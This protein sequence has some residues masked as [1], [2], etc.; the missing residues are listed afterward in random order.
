[1]SFINSILKAFVGDK[2]E[3]DVKAIQPLL[4]K[5]KTF[6]SYLI[7]LSHD[8]LRAKTAFFKQTI[9]D[10]RAEKDAK[11]AALKEEVE[12]ISDIDQR[13]DLYVFIDTLEKEAYE[14]SE[15]VLLEILPEAF[16]VVKETARRF[17]E[18]TQIK[19]TASTKDIELSATKSYVTLE[20][21]HAVWANSWNAA[22]KEI[23][24]DMIHYDVQLIGG[25]VL[26]QGK[27]AEMQT[28]EGKTLVA[29]LPLYLNAL[30]GNGVHLVTV[31]D[32]LAKRDSTWK[33]P[34]FEFHGLTVD[35][36]DN[37]QPNTESRRKAYEADITYGTN[38]EFGFDYLRDNM[39]HS[40][41][42]LV[43]RKHN[44]AIVDEVDSVLIDDA[45]T[46]LIIS[47]PVPQGDRHE[48]NEL[49]P[50]VDNLVTLQR[51]LATQFLTEAK[52][53]IKEG[54]TKD[55][56]F[57]LLR[58]YRSLP[59][60]KALIKFLSEEGIKQ[61]LQKTENHYMQD[62]NREMPKVDEALYFVIEEKNNQVELTDNGIKFLSKDT[63]ES[64]FVLP[65][66]GSEIARIEKMR[67]EKDAEAEEK[68]KLFQ[69]FSIKSE[70]IHTLTQL[71]KAYTLFEKD[72]EYVIM[73]DK[74][75]IVDEQTGRI[76]EGRRYSDGLHQAIEAKENVKI[77]AA[78][79]TFA[80]VTLQNYFRMYSKLAG[81]T[82][83]AVT[84][85][86]ELWQI[87][88]LDVVE[89]PTNRPM[90]RKDQEDLIYKTT[91]EKFNAVIEDVTKLSQ[92]GRPV[93]IG[94][95]SV[96]ISELLS[97]MLKMRN[98][99]HNVLN[100]KMH[101]KEAD[102]VAEA[103]KPG[104]VTIATNMAGRGTDIKLTPEVKAAG[105]LAIIGTERH[106][107]RR[108]DRQL[109]GRAG[110]QGDPGSSQFYVSLEDN[111]MRLFGSERV[112]KVMDRMGLKEGEVIQHSM[113]TKSIER[114]QKKVEENNF[115]VRKRLL[116]YDDVMNSQREVVYKRRRHALHGERLKVDIANMIY[117]T[118]ENIVNDNKAVS[119][120]KN[121]EFDLIRY[122]SISSPVSEGE[123]SKLTEVELSGKVYKVALAYYEEK[124]ARDARESF[125]I[126]KNVFENP[127]NQY[128][129]I[130][131][132][133]TDGQKTLNVVTDLKKAY[134]SHGKQLVAD[135][136][137]N[138]TL[139]IVDEAWKKHLRKMDELK[140]SV[141]LAVHEQKDPLLI[142]K[143]EAFNLF[144]AMLDKVNKE[145]VSFL[146]K[147]DLPN[148][149]ATISEAKEVRQ[150]ENYKTSKD[151][152]PNSDTA[153]AQNR[154][155][156]QTQ[157]QQV[158]ETIVRDAPKI[159]RNDTVTIKH[160]LSGKTETMKYKKAESM[161]AGGEWVL[162]S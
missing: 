64:F 103:G 27:I 74:I 131:V 109:R 53:L 86:G 160:V 42:D 153:A 97:R 115:G 87:Y 39:A 55:G 81:M 122:F 47:G 143:F 63:N 154:E 90:S 25:V 91:R 52:K 136:E 51:N 104:V 151:E 61:L 128:E 69:D 26:H 107:S 34:L 93:L 32:Y 43:Q 132:P 16:A 126:I 49:K 124:N 162:V 11:I 125:P 120:F 123:F 57:Q 133:F 62:N 44:Y 141:Q 82:G 139:A 118:C 100:A 116:E 76:M 1:M 60:N 45:R 117:D 85:A 89:I 71:L 94:T 13:E 77:E 50:K 58:A 48:F 72:V 4:A 147:G 112:A 65:D 146:F 92:A 46:P 70:R 19:V 22:G 105:G 127:N 2:S 6:E 106:D 36:I 7:S 18:N 41:Q 110:R 38:N 68:E 102:I 33:A 155:V 5:I 29:T 67:L 142:Y 111:L 28:G 121:F 158:T 129:R 21:D 73:E 152:I 88:K 135:F 140:Q 12:Q 10:A 119:D 95:T 40:P 35:C 14:I 20:G 17:K 148:Q 114:A 79:Q 37:H 113:M 150:K 8:E 156:G 78:T 31:N 157:R 108:V 145:V 66:I 134:E 101:K 98:I 83:T 96:E 30:T 54:N 137:K 161:I 138:I 56:G 159:N 24:W 130:V 59:K 15:K 23:T 149:S 99:P 75:M 144:K 9:K 84:E 80:T 3:K